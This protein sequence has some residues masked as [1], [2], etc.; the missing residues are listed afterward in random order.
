MFTEKQRKIFRFQIGDKFHFAD[1]LE[2]EQRIIAAFDGEDINALV[3]QSN[4]DNPQEKLRGQILLA[5]KVCLAFQIPPFDRNTGEGTLLSDCIRVW[6]EYW[7]WVAEKKTA[8]ENE[9]ISENV[10][11]GSEGTFS[12]DPSTMEPTAA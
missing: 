10:S 11:L 2:L 3:M 12:L 1:P 7:D 6:N 4:S 5:E 9:P 8:S